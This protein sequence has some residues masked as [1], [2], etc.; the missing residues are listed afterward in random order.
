MASVISVVASSGSVSLSEEPAGI[1]E[2]STAS[3]LVLSS[4]A[5]PSSSVVVERL[6]TSF[7]DG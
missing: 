2:L 5:T 3:S 4:E 1:E 7:S 6:E